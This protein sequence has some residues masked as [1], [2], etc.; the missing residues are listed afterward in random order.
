MLR[1]N[2]EQLLEEIGRLDPPAESTTWDAS[3]FDRFNKRLMTILDGAADRLGGFRDRLEVRKGLQA[4]YNRVDDIEPAVAR[5]IWREQYGFYPQLIDEICRCMGDE[6]SSV[7]TFSLTVAEL[8]YLL[9]L[10]IDKGI[11]RT[12]ALRPIFEFFSDHVQTRQ[13]RKLSFASLQK[14]YSRV[15]PATKQRVKRLLLDLAMHIDTT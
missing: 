3:T 5:E 7:V 11:V 8:L 10:L 13:G 2:L 9:R 12:D 6:Q 15:E 1:D 14:K 4:L